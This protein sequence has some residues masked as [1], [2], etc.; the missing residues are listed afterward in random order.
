LK[1]EWKKKE[2]RKTSWS[3]IEVGSRNLSIGNGEIGIRAAETLKQ[4]WKKKELRKTSWS[5]S[6][7][8]LLIYLAQ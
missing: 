2:L 1:Q 3:G 8:T 6:V 5:G 4:E 7:I